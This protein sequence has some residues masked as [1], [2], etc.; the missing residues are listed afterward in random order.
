MAE[1]KKPR[2]SHEPPR[3]TILSDHPVKDMRKKDGTDAV[4]RITDSDLLT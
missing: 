2:I 1:D 3:I 4:E